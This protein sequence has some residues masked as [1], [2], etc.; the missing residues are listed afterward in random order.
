MEAPGKAQIKTPIIEPQVEKKSI[1]FRPP[2]EINIAHVPY[3]ARL[4]NQMYTREHG[5]FLDMFRQLKI[6]LP[7]VEALQHM[8]KYTKYLKDLL[9]RKDRLGEV[10]SIPLSG[11]SSAVVLNWVPKCYWIRLE[12]GELTPTRMSLSLADRS[13]NYPR[14]LD[15]K[16]DEKVPIILGRPFLR[17]AKALIDVYEGRI[18]LRVGYENVSY[19]IAKPMKHPGDSDDFSGPCHSCLYY[20][21]GTDLVGMDV[22]EK[23]AEIMEDSEDEVV[24]DVS[25]LPEI[26][27]FDI[28]IKGKKGA[29]NIAADH[30]S[31]LEDPKREE[32]CEEEIGDRFPHESID[33]VTAKKQG[34]PWFTDFA[35]YLSM[36]L[37]FKGMTT[38]QKK[39]FFGDVTRYFWN[40]PFL[41]KIGG[42][43]IL[44]R[45]KLRSKWTGPYLV[46]EVFPYEA[47]ELENPDNGTSWKVNGHGLKHYLGGPEDSTDVE[48]TPLDPSN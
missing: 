32:I 29:G 44:R 33:F 25:C 2:P 37:V 39:K 3:P 12:L 17:T 1:V 31:L 28:E 34:L 21:C 35:N 43:R 14:L 10:S 27:E 26:M 7:F 40:D 4:K 48:E 9:K 46:K 19:D 11:D 45:C 23:L 41:S 38:Q 13:V 30:L 20:I 8:P 5:H 22:N 6:N 36:G 42:D 18:T 16:A 47:V 24:D 15:I